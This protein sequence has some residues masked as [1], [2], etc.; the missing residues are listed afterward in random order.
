MKAR[1]RL[2]SD[3]TGGKKYPNGISS[4]VMSMY[5]YWISTSKGKPTKQ[6][7][8]PQFVE[9]SNWVNVCKGVLERYPG[10]ERKPKTPSSISSVVDDLSAGRHD[11]HYFHIRALAEVVDLPAGLFV[12]FTQCVSLE[13]E[14]NAQEPKSRDE[15]L[16]LI[17]GLGRIV[18]YS[19][20]LLE[21][22]N[23]SAD[24]FMRHYDSDSYLPN[25]D[26]LKGWRDAFNKRS[27]R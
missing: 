15:C 25:M 4:T 7:S 6:T 21:A 16:A 19:K 2:Q 23:P 13:R 10:I 27:A 26:V 18:E 14:A 8:R 24:R 9:K 3:Y 20:K 1:I 12:L 5:R 22:D 11:L 17:E